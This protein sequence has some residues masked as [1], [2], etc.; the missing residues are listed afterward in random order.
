MLF[1]LDVDFTGLHVL[2]Q[3]LRLKFTKRNKQLLATSKAI[4][5]TKVA[6]EAEGS[7]NEIA[8]I[9]EKS[10]QGTICI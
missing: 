3:L 7:L 8:E 6:T 4:K 5:F 1:S 2:L 10:K 9:L